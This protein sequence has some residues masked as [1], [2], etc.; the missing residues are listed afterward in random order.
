[1]LSRE[2]RTPSI[3]DQRVFVKKHL[4]SGTKRSRRVNSNRLDRDRSRNVLEID[5]AY[6]SYGIDGVNW[7]EFSKKIKILQKVNLRGRCTVRH[8][9]R[10]IEGKKTAANCHCIEYKKQNDSSRENGAMRVFGVIYCCNIVRNANLCLISFII[11]A[12]TPV[13]VTV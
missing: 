5:T 8:Y 1:M 12:L 11:V 13:S 9:R 2:N 10:G 4:N 6:L 7:R 3:V